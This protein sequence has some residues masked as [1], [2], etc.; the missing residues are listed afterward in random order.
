MPQTSRFALRKYAALK[1]L[2][3]ANCG[4]G[5]L[6][7]TPSHTNLP[8]PSPGM[9]WVWS[10]LQRLGSIRDRSIYLRRGCMHGDRLIVT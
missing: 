3:A 4:G 7:L 1:G 5:G 8:F 10:L 6:L 2:F 9:I